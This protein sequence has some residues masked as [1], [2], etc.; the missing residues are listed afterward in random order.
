MSLASKV[1]LQAA[2]F[3]HMMALELQVF[4]Q[5][6]MVTLFKLYM[7][8]TLQLNI[9]QQEC[10]QFKTIMFKSKQL[11]LYSGKMISLTQNCV[12]TICDT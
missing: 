11:I 4:L 6:N 5:V 7:E 8:E 2:I 1:S 10:Q 3:T 12:I 9:R